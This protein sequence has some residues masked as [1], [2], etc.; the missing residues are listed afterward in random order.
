ML[1]G[2]YSDGIVAGRGWIALMLVILGRWTPVG[3]VVG[4]LLF[5]YVEALQYHLGLSF[6]FLPSQALLSLPYLLV[7]VVAIGAYHGAA[8]PRALMRPYDREARH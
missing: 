2:T 5:G 3:A 8:A 4:G 7:M 1:T 6:K